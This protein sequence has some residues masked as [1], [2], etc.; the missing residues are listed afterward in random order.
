MFPHP[1]SYPKIA[2]LPALQ[3]IHRLPVSEPE[4]TTVK[5]LANALK[6]LS[7]FKTPR[8]RWSVTDLC[9]YTGF[10][11]SHVSKILSEFRN[12]KLLVQDPDS[13]EYSVGASAMILAGHFLS[14]Q[15]IVREAIGHMRR[16][17]T[18][19]GHSSFLS[20]LDNDRVMHLA[21]IQGPHFF[22][23]GT[24]VGMLLA[25]HA[26]AVGKLLY[27]FKSPEG[28]PEMPKGELVRYT[29]KTI[30]SPKELMQQL[31]EIRRTGISST[32]EEHVLGVCAVAVP[33]FQADSRAIA[34]LALMFPRHIANAKTVPVVA[35]R[36]QSVAREI[37]GRLGAP[38][39]PFGSP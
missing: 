10:S 7:A 19:L 2:I 25:P 33:V 29:P 3:R 4:K 1:L 39:Y 9:E 26:S 24:G 18:E 35:E 16:L 21:E 11:K 32:D 23:V 31:K 37:S 17:T 36:L 8:G 22:D 15:G 6:V 38:V 12:A 20:I 14:S 5:A 30:T 27:A 28:G 34:A 13:R